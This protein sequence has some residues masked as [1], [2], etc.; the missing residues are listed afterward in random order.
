MEHTK[1]KLSITLAPD[2][3]RAVD[4]A[5]KRGRGA[6]RSSVIAAWLRRAARISAEDTLRTETVAY[7]ESLSAEESSEN[8][9]IARASSRAARKLELDRG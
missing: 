8:A 4:R 2:L 3:V 9:S 6:S 1:T 5:V 7:Y